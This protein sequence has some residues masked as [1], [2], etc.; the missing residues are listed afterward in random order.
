MLKLCNLSDHI[1]D[2][3]YLTDTVGL[4]KVSRADDEPCDAQLQD[5]VSF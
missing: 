1:A 3:C 4:Q 2:S 5:T